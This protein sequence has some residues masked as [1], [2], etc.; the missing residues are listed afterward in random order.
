MLYFNLMN[1]Y[2]ISKVYNVYDKICVL[3]FKKLYG[4][5]LRQLFCLSVITNNMNYA[6]TFVGKL[7]IFK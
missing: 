7:V 2:N 3:A 6:Q 4:I 1:N 5:I